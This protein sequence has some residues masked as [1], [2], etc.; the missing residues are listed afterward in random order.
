V[1]PEAHTSDEADVEE[2]SD[3]VD[4]E[5]S[6]KEV[7]MMKYLGVVLVAAA[8]EMITGVI[9]DRLGWNGMI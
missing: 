4:D 6:R 1:I 5:A 9:V 3:H 8:A 2:A 7:T